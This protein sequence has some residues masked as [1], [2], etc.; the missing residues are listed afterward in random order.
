MTPNRKKLLTA[1]L[2]VAVIAVP[3]LIKAGRGESS[4]DV[5]IAVAAAQEIRPTILASGVLAYLEEVNL[6]SELV[7]KVRSIEV[8]EGDRVEK[9]Q[10][11]LTLDPETY[12]NAIEREEASRR[13]SAIAIERQRLALSLAE[14]RFARGAELLAK[15]M[16]GQSEFDDLRNARDLARVELQSS[17]EAL[18]RADA[19]LGEA[20]EQLGKTDIRAPIAGTVVDLPIKVGE[21]AIPSNSALAGASLMKIADTSAIRAEL[22]VDEADIARI[23]IGQTV[24]VYATAFPD[25][26]LKGE[27]ERIALAPTLEN[28]ARAYEVFALLD[29][30]ADLALRSGMS[31]RADIFL[32]E[33]GAKLAVPVEAVGTDDAEEGKH[34]RFVW[35]ERD[36]KAHRVVVET[37][38]S[39]D[40]W[41]EIMSGLTA[42]DRVITGPARMLRGLVEG[43]AV[44]QREE[45]KDDTESSTEP[46]D[47]GAGEGDADA[48]PDAE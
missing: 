48:E 16:I 28:Q 43:E 20:R 3:L 40:R 1:A 26:A 31:A 13:Q 47:E 14:T 4:K 33:G 27:V 32:G 23:A 9:G 7:A 18:R 6:T 12:R 25:V 35:V 29:P 22:K 45:E 41:E 2:V 11:L 10:L 17:E 37:G 39:D 46:D 36:G 19:I 34:E 44:R 24:D 38:L 42:G 8:A 21:T 5:D 15:K 30:P